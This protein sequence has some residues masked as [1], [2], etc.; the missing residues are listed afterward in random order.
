MRI[1]LDGLALQRR[2]HRVTILTVPDSQ[3]FLRRTEH[4]LPVIVQP[5]SHSFDLQAIYRLVRL[6]K[7]EKYQV[8]NTHSSVDS[9]VASAAAKLAGVPVL[10]RTRHLSVPLPTHPF[11]FVYHWPDAIVTTAEAI[12]QRMIAVNGMDGRRIIS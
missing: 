2:G 6:F 11:N 9:W 8:V 10:V 1:V 5:L 7:R 12:R 3:I 4:G